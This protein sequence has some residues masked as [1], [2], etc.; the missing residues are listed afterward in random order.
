MAESV[1]VGD[2]FPVSELV[3]SDGHRLDLDALAG[4]AVVYFY[5]A[6]GTDGC[7]LQAVEFNRA[8]DD[9]EAAERRARGRQRRR[10]GEPSLLRRGPRPAL[11]ARVR[12]R[13]EL[14][15]KLGLIKDY[16]EYGKLAGR[17]T[18]LLDRDAIV[19]QTWAPQE[20]DFH[21]HPAR[22]ST[23]RGRSRRADA[24][25]PRAAG[26]VRADGRRRRRRDA[27]H[28]R[29][30]VRV[31]GARAERRV[32]PIG[33]SQRSAMAGHEQSLFVLSGTATLYL[34]GHG[35]HELTPDTAAYIASGESYSIEND[36]PDPLVA[37][38][39]D[40]PTP[41]DA[42]TPALGSREVHGQLRDAARRGG[43]HRPHVPPA[44]RS[45]RRLRGLHAVHGRDPRR[46]RA[47]PQPHL[48]RGRLR[49]R[50]RGLPAHGRRDAPDQAGSCI[51][52]PPLH[53]HC[54]ENAGPAR[55]RVLGVFQPAGSPAARYAEEA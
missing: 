3:A 50:G 15:D 27:H 5:P 8:V 21:D 35:H 38:V 48:R 49:R 30:L 34:D 26:R 17:V 1:K 53:M 14:T 23:P 2:K 37:L 13:A 52:L 12:P 20:Q 36:G 42:D 39:V 19:R 45:R 46:P 32:F 4:P 47:R 24:R 25:T 6:D 31:R 51:Y 28:D 43:R 7:T 40:A 29:P 55:M 16:G 10:R 33:R 41:A 11:P 9:Y 22:P 44:R 18:I 54:L